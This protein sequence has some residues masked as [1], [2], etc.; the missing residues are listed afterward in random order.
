M[1]TTTNS[2]NSTGTGLL[3]SP[4]IGSGLDVNSIISQ[5]MAIE[6]QPLQALQQKQADLNT[7]ISAFGTLKSS[8]STFQSAMNGFSVDQF[9]AHT[10]TSA[11]ETVYTATADGTA[12]NG[13]YQIE[14]VSLAQ[15]ERMLSSAY[16]DSDSTTVGSAGDQMTIQV[17]SD[18]ANAFT[19]TIGGQT[20]QGVRDAINNATD[21]TGVTASIM[22]T[23]AG[24]QLVLS[25]DQTG[26]ANALTLS[27]TD[28]GG[29]SI[30]D[31]LSMTDVQAASDAVIN[32]D[33]QQATRSTNTISDVIQGVTLNLVGQS[34]SGVTT[35]LTVS[36]DQSTVK[37]SVQ[38]FVDA[39]NALHKSLGSLQSGGLSGDLSTISVIQS[40]LYGVLNTPASGVSNFYSYLAE[41]GV[42][43]QK[44]G[45][46]AVDSTQ[47]DNALSTDP[48]GVAQLFIDGTQGFA[49][50]FADLAGQLTEA[51]GLLDSETQGLNDNVSQLQTQ[52][53][54]E[55]ANLDAVQKNLQQ[56]YSA[57]D[58][59]LGTMQGTSNFLTQQLASLPLK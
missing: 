20:L 57:L 27:Y 45:T 3:S 37:K 53:N 54:A 10:A 15:S 17:G 51:G 28:S 55:Q 21:N 5:L 34:V 52:I 2:I 9:K 46:M 24:Y 33:N 35:A 50:R 19:V 16:A 22:H 36:S 31:P 49:V 39:Y 40:E 42:A 14:V 7:E 44:D 4:G 12:A 59:L 47:L 23:D 32:V 13:V 58:A 43:I 29:G 18:P 25:S 11:D 48:S 6:S 1:A 56:Q 30:A 8:L 41:I 26:T 38:S